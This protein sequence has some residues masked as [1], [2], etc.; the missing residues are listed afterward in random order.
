MFND[1]RSKIG[2]DKLTQRMLSKLNGGEVML[3]H[4]CGTTMGANPDAPEQMLIALERVLKVAEQ[5]GMRSI[6]I[7]DMMAKESKAKAKKLSPLEAYDC[8]VVASVGKRISCGICAQNG[9]AGRSDLHF[10]KRAFTGK[11]VV[12]EDGSQLEKGDQVLELHFDNKN[13]LRSAAAPFGS[14]ARYQNDSC[15]A[16]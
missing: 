11:T 13:C 3:L 12:M 1:W 9:L 16:E 15:R 14:A 10:R 4:D 2:A 8:L 6:R 7:D 5:K